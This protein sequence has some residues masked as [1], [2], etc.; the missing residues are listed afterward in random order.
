MEG[1]VDCIALLPRVLETALSGDSLYFSADR[2]DK[3][4]IWA[5]IPSYQG[6][7][8]EFSTGSG[9]V[10]LMDHFDRYEGK[11]IVQCLDNETLV[12]ERVVYFKPGTPRLISY[13]KR[14]A[15]AV[16]SPRGMV[17][18]PGGIFTFKISK[19]N[20]FIPYPDFIHGVEVTVSPFFMDKTPVTNAQFK[21]FLDI[22]NYKPSD[23]MNFLKH[24]H[25]GSYPNEK[26]NY[27]V[28]YVSLEDAR[29]YCEW[30][31]KRL[32]TEKEWQYAAQG[33]DGRL[34][35]WGSEYDSTRCNHSLEEMTPVDKYPG[36]ESPF[37]VMD[38]VGNVWQLTD[39]VYDNGS[40]YFI[41]IRG[42]SYYNPTSSWWYV[43]GGPRPLDRSQI[44]LRVSQG[45]ERNAT[46]GFRCVKD[47]E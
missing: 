46:V 39:D 19:T 27:P 12:D 47:S 36:G 3:I 4:R 20:S 32:P 45:F 34:W 25:N 5:G 6:K 14:T 9:K 40:H 44:L 24:W 33:K 35:P 42:G 17:L 13:E 1:N 15:T 38:L 16:T 37:G 31:E 18:I 29:A 23:P 22:A 2:G 8:I 21:E 10:R 26:G 7:F 11:F 43:K 41:I 30:A 28:V